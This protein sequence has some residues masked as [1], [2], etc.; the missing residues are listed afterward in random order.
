MRRLLFGSRGG[1]WAKPEAMERQK[2]EQCSCHKLSFLKLSMWLLF[3]S[4]TI[5][6]L[7][8]WH[9]STY[10]KLHSF[11]QSFIHA[12]IHSTNTHW[13]STTCQALLASGRQQKV[14]SCNSVGRGSV[15]KGFQKY[16]GQVLHG[17]EN[18]RRPQGRFSPRWSI[19]ERR[20]VPPKRMGQK[21]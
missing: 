11:T 19:R 6:V 7:S 12:I 21:G 5:A 18:E 4:I 10:S 3:K 20:A 9:G 1:V 14:H 17:N 2:P 15:P 16:K 8:E 13:L